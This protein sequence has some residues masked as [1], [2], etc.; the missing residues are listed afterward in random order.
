MQ[1]LDTP[2]LPRSVRRM[3]DEIN[4]AVKKPQCPSRR[5]FLYL[6]TIAVYTL[7]RVSLQTLGG[8]GIIICST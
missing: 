2:S 1:F 8:Y 5:V 4:Q 7:T 3:K 6:A